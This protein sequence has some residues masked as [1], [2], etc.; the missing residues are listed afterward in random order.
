M[1][2]AI[3]I[4]TKQFQDIFK[5]SG[6]L[7]QFII[8][9]LFAFILTNV[10]DMPV[11]FFADDEFIIMFAR[12]FIGM[13]LVSTISLTIAEDRQ[14]KALRFLMMAGVKS[15]EYL[16]GV[17]GMFF[18]CALIVNTLF[19]MM[20]PSLDILQ[21]SIMLASMMLG[22]LASLFLGAILGITS[23]NEQAASSVSMAAGSFLGFGPMIANMSGNETMERVIG[24]FYTKNFVFNDF[25]SRDALQSMLIISVNAAVLMT[26]FAWV[27]AKQ[28]SSRKGGIIVNRKKA[29]AI[30]LAVVILG[31]GG[32]GYSIWYNANYLTTDNAWVTTTLVPVS[33]NAPGRLERFALYEG[34]RVNENE[35][36]G[37]VEGADSMR[38][39]LDGLI[40]Q[41]NAVQNQFISP[42]DTVAIIADMS[43]LHIRANIEETDILSVTPG[44]RAYVTIDGFGNRQFGGYISNIGSATQATLAGSASFFNA[45]SSSRTTHFIPIEITIVDD[46]NLDNIIGANARVRIP[47]R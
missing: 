47:I 15:H 16:L 5:N 33:S 1:N 13:S 6:V 35:I 7:I 23:K 8:F 18:A 11:E 29:V 12:M 20:M 37:W 39:P 9:P 19:T 36:L 26:A 17:G 21:R 24:I 28:E 25:Q 43:N 3:A 40:I 41:I 30:L 44:G 2:S 27:Y 4:F 10:A 45:G 46:I 34:Q 31:G 42:V 38:A 32:I 14:S 22:S